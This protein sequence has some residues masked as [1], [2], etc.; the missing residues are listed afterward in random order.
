MKALDTNVLVRFLVKDDERQ[1][2]AVYQVF[3]EAEAH[4]QQL[5]VPLLVI[6][7]TLWV[8]EAVYEI[9]KADILESIAEL[10][11][12]PILKFEA[13]PA[14]RRFVMSAHESRMELADLLIGHSAVYSV[15]DAVLTFDKKASKSPLF[16]LIGK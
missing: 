4:K 15:S 6:L 11:L 2:K 14:V 10:L 16:E 5:W 3:K 9:Q 8:L 7:E 1:A 13:Q 12:M